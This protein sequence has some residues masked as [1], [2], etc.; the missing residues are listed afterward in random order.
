MD[1]VERRFRECA[2]AWKEECLRSG[3]SR[4]DELCGSAHYREIVSMGSSV[5]PLLLAEME[6]RPDH[7]YIALSEITKEDPVP[8]RSHGKLGEIAAAWVGWGR[9]LRLI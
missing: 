9:A 7:W 3:S 6:A 4:L 1:S 2:R 5:V 8:E